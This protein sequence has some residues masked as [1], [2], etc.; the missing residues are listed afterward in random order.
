ML[1][2][3]DIGDKTI[4][5]HEQ[6][7]FE[8]E[9]G[10]TV[11]DCA[12]VLAHYLEVLSPQHLRGKRTIELGSG[13]GLVGLVAAAMG[14]K[15]LLT[16]L[17]KLVPGLRRNVEANDLTHCT[18]VQALPWGESCEEQEPRFD[19]VLLADCLYDSST[20]DKLVETLLSLTHPQTEVLLAHELRD[21]SAECFDKLRGKG[22]CWKEIPHEQLHPE[23]ICDEIKIFKLTM[24]TVPQPSC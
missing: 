21:T 20:T 16:D 18:R 5:I 10:A 17:P 12:L 19:L 11:W 7:D 23:W 22:I 2:E 3:I 14:A 15:V 8:D 4:V 9:V 6:V 13:T 1:R 24:P